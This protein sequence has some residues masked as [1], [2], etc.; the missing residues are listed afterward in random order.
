ME[1]TTEKDN[2]GI[3]DNILKILI[4]AESGVYIWYDDLQ[5]YVRCTFPLARYI[6][7]DN[8]KKCGNRFLVLSEGDLYMASPKRVNVKQ[9]ELSEYKN[10]FNS[11]IDGSFK[12]RTDMKKLPNLS[13][14][15][16]FTVDPNGENFA[17]RQVGLVI[18]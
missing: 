11:N 8:I 12:V 7:I 13:R 10:T 14:I 3:E 16:W 9:I 18:T 6:K 5:K 15:V 2:S 4:L 17:V 1:S